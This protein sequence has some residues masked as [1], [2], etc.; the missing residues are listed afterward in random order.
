[1]RLTVRLLGSVDLCVDGRAASVSGLRRKAVLAALALHAGEV[2]T[3]DRLIDIV[4]GDEPPCRAVNTLQSHI[5]YLR[6]MMGGLGAIIA[7]RPGYR[8]EPGQVSIDAFEAEELVRQGLRECDPG[9]VRATLGEALAMW[10]GPSL[11]DLAGLPYFDEQASRL[12]GVRWTA[13]RAETAA[14][15]EL[16]EY[17]GLIPELEVLTKEQPYDEELHAQLMLALYCSNRQADALATYQRLRRALADELGVEPGPG[18]RE[19]ESAILRQEASLHSPAIDGTAGPEG[20]IWIAESAAAAGRWASRL[21]DRF[22]D[23]RLRA[24]LSGVDPAETLRGFLVA[25]GFR[26]G[27]IPPGLH[28]RIML[29]RSALAGKRM[30]ILLDAARDAA[31]VR[32]LL[33][34]TPTCL[35]LVNGRSTL[36]P[37]IVT[38][39]ARPLPRL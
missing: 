22:P 37:L 11:A 8:L 29:Y 36:T 38:E 18:L 32:P 14:R 27:D 35:T 34:G 19:L 26:P 24:D 39:G 16:G 20:G 12:D 5:S 10:H 13:V 4:W 28:S 3:T 2:V 31:Q 15:L 9:R 30:V 6:R 1:M 33:P 7:R 23:G 21:S 17:A 25:L